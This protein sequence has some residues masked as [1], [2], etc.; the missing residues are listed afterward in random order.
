MCRS[1]GWRSY[2][3]LCESSIDESARQVI[4]MNA[5]RLDDPRLVIDPATAAALE[6]GRLDDPFAVLGPHPDGAGIVVRAFLPPAEGVDL[7]GARD[8]LL[9]SMQP[10]APKGLFVGRIGG[11]GYRL[12]IRW[13]G[14][15]TQIT[16]DPYSFGVLLG[17]L[18]VYLL[19][20]G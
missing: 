16:E 18:D 2:C 6:S 1:Q 4:P 17:E 7:I 11:G 5:E 19:A 8:E 3:P 12:R 13:P 14:G 10:A 20:E 9:A 15:V